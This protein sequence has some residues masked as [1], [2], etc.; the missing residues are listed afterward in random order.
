MRFTKRIAIQSMTGFVPSVGFTDGSYWIPDRAELNDPRLRHVVGP[1][2][3]E[4]RLAQLYLKRGLN[5][6]IEELKKF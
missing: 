1:S 6:L 4:Q 5:G 2:P 3:E